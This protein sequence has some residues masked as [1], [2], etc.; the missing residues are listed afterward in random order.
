MSELFERKYIDIDVD[1]TSDT[2]EIRRF[3]FSDFETIYPIND[4][5]TISIAQ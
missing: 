4:C 1:V 2:Y 5:E 3:V